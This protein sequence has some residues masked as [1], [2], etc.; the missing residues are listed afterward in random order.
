MKT[1]RGTETVA[2]GIYFNVK[3]LRFHAVDEEGPLPG[4]AEDLCRRVPTAAMLV[5]GP[6]AGLAYAVFL[7][8]IGFVML[9]G[10]AVRRGGDGLRRL[11][12]T[13]RRAL[14]PAVR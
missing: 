5:V 4:G 14:R 13:A 11:F 1:Y 12:R 3:E 6:L 9:G 8:L 10:I 7:P 2:P